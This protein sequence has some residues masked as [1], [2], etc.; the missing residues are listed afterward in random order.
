MADLRLFS[1]HNRREKHSTSRVLS[2]SQAIHQES[3]EDR[4]ANLGYGTLKNVRLPTQKVPCAAP[5]KNGNLQHQSA[6]S[7]SRSFTLVAPGYDPTSD[8][9]RSRGLMPN[10]STNHGYTRSGV[11]KLRSVQSKIVPNES[12]TKSAAISQKITEIERTTNHGYTRSRVPKLTSV[13]NT[14][15]PN[16]SGKKS[17]PISQ[18]ITEIERT[19]GDNN[20]L[21]HRDDSV[22]DSGRPDAHKCRRCEDLVEAYPQSAPALDICVIEEGSILSIWGVKQASSENA[23]CQRS[24]RGMSVTTSPPLCRYCFQ[25]KVVSDYAASSKISRS[26]TSKARE[27]NSALAVHYK[28]RRMNSREL[29]YKS[30]LPYR[31]T[32]LGC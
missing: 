11:A 18:K 27:R 13:Q 10:G 23:L 22:K 8:R 17:T 2:N 6:T 31:L 30:Y 29:A 16:E 26:L 15:V 3:L 12:G 24:F 7:V 20:S 32:L 19:A 21:N 4:I 14:I 9:S 25:S 28:Q 1:V 5:S